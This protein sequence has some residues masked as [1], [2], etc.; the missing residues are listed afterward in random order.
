MATEEMSQN[1]RPEEHVVSRS[2]GK[3]SGAR[4]WYVIHTYSGYED[5]V[6]QNLRLT[7]V[8]L[9]VLMS[10]IELSLE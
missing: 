7:V 4:N 5:Q 1:Q 2:T 3:Q 10:Q 8:H 6:S 9:V